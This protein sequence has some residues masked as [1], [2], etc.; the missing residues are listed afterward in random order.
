[1]DR[2]ISAGSERGGVNKTTRKVV[3]KGG[4]MEI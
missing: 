2:R 1:M 4:N 3:G